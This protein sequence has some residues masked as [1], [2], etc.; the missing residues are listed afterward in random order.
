MKGHRV[1][2]LAAVLVLLAA[3]PAFGHLPDT[4]YARFKVAPGRFEA[5]FS[6]DLATLQRIVPGL[7]ANGDRQVTQAELQAQAPAVFAF[8]RGQVRL[9]IDGAK[10]DWGE[11]QPVVFPPGNGTAIPEQNYHN[12]G[13]L[14]HFLFV[15][16]LARPL[17]DFW[18]QFDLFAALGQRHTVLG[19]IEQGGKE[20]EVLFRDTEP[21][22]LYDT[23]Y[24]PSVAA[25]P[26]SPAATEPA[27]AAPVSADSPARPR[28]PASRS[29]DE[30]S[31]WRQMASFFRLGVEHIFLGYDHILFLLSLLVVSRFGELV[32]IVTS[33]TAAHT[34]TLILAA[35]EVVH[36]PSRL[37]ETAIAAT[38]VYVAVE[39]FWV[40]S[41]AHRWRLTFF[42]G[43]IH[44]FGFAGVLRELGLPTEGLVRSLVSFNVGV[45]AGQLM[46]VTALLPAVTL[47]AR[48]AYRR[49]AQG[50]ISAAI[51][52]CGGAWFVDRAFALGFMPF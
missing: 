15:R 25:A 49:P 34:I 50:T 10:A 32:K 21:D 19:A 37:V 44:G 14:V 7:D 28:S 13:S 22:Y 29:N 27:A 38:I 33:F 31:A 48:W 35:L 45:E 16:R 41:T 46:I 36:V 39:N 4:S 11:S 8:L 17:A 26:D 12:A 24:Q 3:A 47:L 2:V 30:T 52:A 18:V 20:Q 1:R 42:C 43:L 40:K 9:E 51:A 5:K 23:G 6:Y